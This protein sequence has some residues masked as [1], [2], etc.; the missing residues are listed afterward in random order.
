[1]RRVEQHPALALGIADRGYVLSQGSV[2]L[3]GTARDLL[4]RLEE[5]EQAYLSIVPGSQDAP[6]PM[7]QK[8]DGG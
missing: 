7:A 3:S 6:V 2:R 5:I 8:H 4:G 1:V